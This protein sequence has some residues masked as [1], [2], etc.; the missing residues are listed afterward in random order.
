MGDVTYKITIKNYYDA[1]RLVTDEKTLYTIPIQESDIE[2]VLTDPTVSCEINKTGTFEFTIYPNHPYYHALAQMRTIM[3]VEYDG[4]TIFRGRILTIDNTM[5]GVKKVHCEGSLAFLMDSIQIGVPEAQRAFV[6]LQEYIV[7]LLD[8]HNQQM[9]ESG[10][11]DKCIYPGYIPDAY[12]S[13]FSQKQI[14]PNESGKFGSNGTEQTMNAVESLMKK[15]GGFFRTRYS[16]EDQ[17]TYLDWCRLWFRRDLENS[18]PIAITQNI[19]DA[20]SN[21]EVDNIFTALIPVGSK[22]GEDVYITDYKTNIHGKNNRILVPQIT[23]VYSES[24]LDTGYVTKDIYEKAVTRYG[25]IYK[26]E[27]FSNADTPAKLWK[28][29]CEW[30]KNNY[31]GGITAYDLSA[32]DM[33]HID[34]N[35]VKYLVGDCISLSIPSDMTELDEYNPDTHSNVVNRTLLS[36]KYDLH[37]PE[38]N[39]YN[40]GIPSDILNVEYGSK[41]TSKSKSGGGGGKGGAGRGAG[42]KKNNDDDNKRDADA[43]EKAQEALAWKL[44]WDE[45]YNNKEYET[46]KKTVNGAGIKPALQTSQLIVKQVLSDPDVDTP[47]EVYERTAAVL[48]GQKQAAT[49]AA[50]MRVPGMS[51]LFESYKKMSP[52]GRKLLELDENYQAAVTS[53]SIGAGQQALALKGKTPEELSNVAQKVLDLGITDDMDPETASSLIKEVT[54]GIQLPNTIGTFGKT[55]DANGNESSVIDLGKEALTNINLTGGGNDGK[56]SAKVGVKQGKWLIQMNEPLSYKEDG[57][58]K[59][60]PDGVIDADDYATL[61]SGVQAIPSFTTQIGA[62]KTVIAENVD[63]ININAGKIKALDGEIDT[64]KAKMITTDSLSA[65]ITFSGTVTAS[66]MLNIPSGSRLAIYGSVFY[67]GNRLNWNRLTV[68]TNA[69]TGATKTISFLGIVGSS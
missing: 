60:L 41:S 2:N 29:A 25:I 67:N 17:R 66:Y 10:E 65:G 55:T 13:T 59:K 31:V 22:D 56:G 5:S 32:V 42:Q 52:T 50:N 51:K 4:D 53:M 3:R 47:G 1:G 7:S 9:M 6:T 48:N 35:V 19:I 58:T 30:I 26:V 37:H 69:A 62:F 27:N 44:V 33:H 23:Q 15:F 16:E 61:K 39:S 34:H 43:K 8:V 45:S 64:L 36:I 28:Y 40:A 54:N 21:S 38:K 49:F 12:P 14:I 46:L 68:V 11:T 57:E 24:E 18:Q 63:A 20:Q